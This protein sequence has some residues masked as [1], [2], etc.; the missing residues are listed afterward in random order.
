VSI[1]IKASTYVVEPV[2]AESEPRM[3]GVQQFP[4]DR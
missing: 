2:L 1:F 3:D 4:L